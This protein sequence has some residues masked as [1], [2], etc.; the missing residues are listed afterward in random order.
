[1]TK[2]SPTQSDLLTTV[3]AHDDGAIDTPD[4]AKA[5]V[6]ALIKRGYLISIPRTDGPSR[7]VI[8]EAGRAAVAPPLVPDAPSPGPKGPIHEEPLV[9]AAARQLAMAGAAPEAPA[10]P[11]G[12]V[13]ALV[14]L[15]RRPEGATIADMMQATGW[16]AHSVRGA[17]SGGIKKGLGL[18]VTSDK[19]DGHRAYRIAAE[20]QA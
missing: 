12:K 9:V 10:A 14:T 11:K 13:G 15:L 17:M 3:A 7:L 20:S 2:L 18:S 6:A 19:T 8:T 16:Q 4:G 1:M 5:A